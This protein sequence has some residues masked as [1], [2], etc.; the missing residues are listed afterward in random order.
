MY[1]DFG[2]KS[3]F[4][5]VFFFH[6]L[7]FSLLLIIKGLNNTDKS[8][9]WLS[10]FTLLSSFYIA[11]FMFG[12]AGWYSKSHYRDILFYIPFQQLFFLPP[13]L[14]FY[15][16]TLFDKSFLFSRKHFVHFLPALFYLIYSIIVFVTDK[17]VL[18]EYYF[19]KDGK[20]KD[21]A[22]WYQV[23]GF[24]SLAFYLI[25]SLRIYKNY[26]SI[27]YDTVSFA[28]ILMFKWAKRFLVAFLLLL[29][30]RLL[31]FIL[32]PEW[33]SFGKK[34]WYYLCFSG[35]FYYISISG[36]VSSQRSI[37][38][39]NDLSESPDSTLNL[40]DSVEKEADL[41]EKN[42][43]ADLDIWKE[44]V[45]SLM[46]VNRLYE[47]PELTLADFCDKLG[48]HSKRVSQIINQG[49][50]MNFNDFVNHY[51]VKAMIKRI[52]EGE[53]NI[54]TLLSLALDSGFNSKSTF[55]RA[56]KRYTSLSPKE[57]IDKKHSK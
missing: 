32:N 51:R 1:F 28:D 34:F 35:L 43:I 15:F 16:R 23:S 38:S 2:L 33:D 14:Y 13:V 49:F 36:Y 21:L 55:N 56:F 44:K 37:I 9:I 4:L 27:V 24:F 50:G 42:Q 30:I 25:Q 6:G 17:I 29:A 5:F 12:Y 19:Y 47:N 54:Q 41:E 57:F 8:S 20:D 40:K 31:F 48:T 26:K 39:F 7:V 3:S 53:H 10:L 18:K 11:P 52:Q 45:E 22:T 46:V